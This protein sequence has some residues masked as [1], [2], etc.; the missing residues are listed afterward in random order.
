MRSSQNSAGAPFSANFF[1]QNVFPAP[2]MPTSASRMG[3]SLLVSRRIREFSTIACARRGSNPP[4]LGL[5]KNCVQ[6]WNLSSRTACDTLTQVVRLKTTRLLLC[7]P[8]RRVCGSSRRFFRSPDSRK[9][10]TDNL[11]LTP[12]RTG[13]TR[14]PRCRFFVTRVRSGVTGQNQEVLGGLLARGVFGVL[15]VWKR[16]SFAAG[17]AGRSLLRHRG[18]DRRALAGFL[19]TPGHRRSEEH[20]SELQSRRD[21]V[22]RLLLEKKKKK[23]IMNTTT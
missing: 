12:V 11:R 10:S 8:V 13:S 18:H 19:E 1:A 4:I 3:L 17:A 6:T 7:S 21:L 16:Q 15:L 5:S 2:D 22:C 9:F 14:N 23:K 20:T